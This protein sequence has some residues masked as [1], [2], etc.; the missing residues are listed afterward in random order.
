L[1][2]GALVI[3]PTETVYG[4]AASAANPEAMRR[5]RQVKG[6]TDR[7]PFTVHLGYR[8]DAARYVSSPSPVL[9]RLARKGWPGPLTLIA[10]QADPQQAEIA[11]TLPASQLEEIYYEG[12]VGLRCPDHSAAQRLLSEAGVPIVAS[13]ANLT[14]ERPPTDLESALRDLDGRVDYAIDG[15]RTRFNAASTVVEVRGNDW[16]IRR[17]GALDERAIRKLVRSTVLMVC[18]GN[19]CRS[20]IA[21]YLF[22]HLLT[23]QLG[24]SPQD[25]TRTGYEVCSAGTAAFP[26]GPASAGSVEELSRR[27]IDASGHCSQPLTAELVQRADRIYVMSPE[28]RAQ[29]IDLV[30]GA[31]DRVEL[32]DPEGPIVDPVGG[33]PEQYRTAAAHIERAVGARVKEFVDEDR[34]W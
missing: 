34:N 18:T 8:R 32:L 12:T 15:Q 29:V 19:S 14:G 24:C 7:R 13:S 23:V 17:P 26:G 5:L 27:G 16:V 6:T 3:F 25:L 4:L 33:G 30:P 2:D 31:S 22:R 21:E 1:R 20:P 11:G 10:E 9:R 28:H